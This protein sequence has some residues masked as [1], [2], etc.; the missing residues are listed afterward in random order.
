MS[1]SE[2]FRE[3]EHSPVPWRQYQLHVPLFYQDIRFMSVTILAPLKEIRSILPS[4]RLK[5]YR[6]TP[7][8]GALSISAYQYRESDLEPYNEVAIGV[9]VTIDKETP[10]FTGILRKMP[11]SPMS[12]SRHLPVSTEIAREVG[13][14]F[15][16]YPK[17]IADI[18]FVDEDEWLICELNAKGQNVLE[19][20]GRKLSL[21]W[22][23]RYRVSPITFRREHILRSEFVISER[24]MGTSSGRGDVRLEL[25]KG[26]IAEELRN[27]K[28]GRVLSYAYCPQA[29]GI[30]TPVF[31]SFTA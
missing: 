11:P 13:V 17:F 2:F 12:F 23:P 22:H 8:H 4:P 16:G 18:K 7:W 9:P 26:A 24:A 31:E 21:K 10:V 25:G 20:H 1:T 14:E 29:Q 27:L 15:A 5:P 19:I 28:L 3:I 6:I 30:L